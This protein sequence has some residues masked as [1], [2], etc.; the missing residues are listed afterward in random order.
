MSVLV[1][2]EQ[3]KRF[4]KLMCATNTGIRLV[5]QTQSYFSLKTLQ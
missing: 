4:A 3:E 1:N 5:K 2:A